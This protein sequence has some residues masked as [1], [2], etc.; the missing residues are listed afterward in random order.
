[1]DGVPPTATLSP[2]LIGVSLKTSPPAGEGNN[3]LTLS[4]Q[5]SDPGSPAASGVAT[6]TVAIEV[7]DWQGATVAGNQFATVT[8][9]SWQVDYP[10]AGAPYGQY[11]VWVNL[12]DQAG[13]NHHQDRQETLVDFAAVGDDGQPAGRSVRGLSH[14]QDPQ[15]TRRSPGHPGADGG[16]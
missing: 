1:M 13:G 7:L 8:G 9:T 5:A 15:P 10:F 12:E 14:R 4:G 6:N 2:A 16:S 11:Q 3:V